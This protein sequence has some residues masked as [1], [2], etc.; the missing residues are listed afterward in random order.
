MREQ[1]T[2]SAGMKIFIACAV[3]L[4]AAAAV[5]TIVWIVGAPVWKSSVLDGVFLTFTL[6]S[7]VGLMEW[8]FIEI[9]LD[10]IKNK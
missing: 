6:I 7:T 8:L 2:L 5:A 4:M 3:L 1:V 10:I 9:L